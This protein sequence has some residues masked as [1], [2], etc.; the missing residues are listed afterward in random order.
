MNVKVRVFIGSRPHSRRR[1]AP[2][3]E[4]T[5]C[6]AI[7]TAERTPPIVHRP[8]SPWP[9]LTCQSPW[10]CGA[11]LSARCDRR[12]PALAWTAERCRSPGLRT[13]SPHPRTESEPRQHSFAMLSTCLYTVTKSRSY[14]YVHDRN[15]AKMVWESMKA[16]ADCDGKAKWNRKVLTT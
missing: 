14:A 10:Q 1:Q 5:S 7:Q 8:P 9:G 16:L 3:A 11:Q 6:W 2:T 13:P 12:T 15:L 4:M